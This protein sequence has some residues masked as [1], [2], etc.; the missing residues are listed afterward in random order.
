MQGDGPGHGQNQF[1]DLLDGLGQFGNEVY[2]QAVDET[3]GRVAEGFLALTDRYTH[4]PVASL[5]IHLLAFGTFAIAEKSL[6]FEHAT[7]HLAV[8]NLYAVLVSLAPGRNPFVRAAKW[9]VEG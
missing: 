4:F 8:I 3:V 2:R 6:L 1:F 5:P 7:P 9:E